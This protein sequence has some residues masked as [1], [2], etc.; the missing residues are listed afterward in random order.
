[1]SKPTF[2]PTPVDDAHSFLDE[3]NNEAVSSGFIRLADYL[4]EKKTSKKTAT[5][6][7]PYNILWRAI[8][9]YQKQKAQF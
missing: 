9:A 7:R 8:S 4:S 3:V 6:A 2:K 5:Q 1:M